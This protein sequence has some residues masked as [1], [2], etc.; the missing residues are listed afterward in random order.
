MRRNQ[1]KPRFEESQPLS[2]RQLFAMSEIFPGFDSWYREH[3]GVRPEP[4]TTPESAG[5]KEAHSEQE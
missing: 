5:K 4:P 3:Y 2:E 1:R